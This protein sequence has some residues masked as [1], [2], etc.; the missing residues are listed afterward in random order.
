MSGR[1][2]KRSLSAPHVFYVGGSLAA[3]LLPFFVRG[4]SF[5]SRQP[6]VFS[7]FVL[8]QG[9]VIGFTAWMTWQ[10]REGSAAS[11]D[12]LC[13]LAVS[14]FFLGIVTEYSE[15]TWDWRAYEGAAM[16][17]AQGKNPYVEADYLYPPVLAQA[18]GAFIRF[19]G[20]TGIAST[21][22][23]DAPVVPELLFFLWQC[24]Q[25]HSVVLSYLLGRVMLRRLDLVDWRW[26]LALAGLFVLNV[27]IQRGLRFSQPA[28]YPLLAAFLVCLYYDQVPWM[29]GLSLSI[30]VSLKVFPLVLL[31]PIVLARRTRLLLWS[32]AWLALIAAAS[33]ASRHGVTYWVS[34]IDL[35]RTF[36]EPLAFRDNSLLSVARN[37]SRILFAEAF[38]VW[39][40][41][42]MQIITAGWLTVRMLKRAVWK[43]SRPADAWMG[44]I[45]DTL[46]LALIL[47]PTVW[48][49]YFVFLIPTIMWAWRVAPRKHRVAVG[50]AVTFIV[51]VPV[52][53]VFLLSYVRLAGMLLLVLFIPAGK[54]TPADASGPINAR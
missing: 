33:L 39:V 20:W 48:E 2:T 42:L 10:R 49:H 27:P 16:A 22:T 44:N 35:L 37:W 40:G 11:V 4:V 31:F 46:C 50:L 26:E 34:F 21:A 6:S 12:I 25:F 14:L 28:L 9:I 51:L 53:D 8:F 43:C 45:A 41:R 15:E 52:F 5:A 1:L 47:S 18:G 23:G 36:P 32:V 7:L 24:L 38:P 17:V 3:A 30:A 13:F 19:L 54:P 29:A